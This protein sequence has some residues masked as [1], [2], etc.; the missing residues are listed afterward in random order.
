VEAFG[1]EQQAQR[2]EH[3]GL[4]VGDQHTRLGRPDGV[5]RLVARF[6][7][8]ALEMVSDQHVA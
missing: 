2:L 1:L 6:A 7:S 3:V 4:V 8:R 5:S